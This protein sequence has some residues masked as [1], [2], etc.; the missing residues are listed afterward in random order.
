MRSKKLGMANDHYQWVGKM[1]M[2]S[3]G[4]LV[5]LGIVAACAI[6]VIANGIYWISGMGAKSLKM[7]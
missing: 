7:K 4:P 3:V 2:S 1:D 6:L 5:R